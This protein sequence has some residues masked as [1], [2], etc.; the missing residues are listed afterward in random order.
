VVLSSPRSRRVTRTRTA[1]LVDAL[2]HT[3]ALIAG[4]VTY[5]IVARML[6]A[7]GLGLWAIIG[8]ASFLPLLCDMGL[9]TAVQRAAVGDDEARTRRMVAL[10]TL[11]VLLLAPVVSSGL[12]LYFQSLRAS[13]HALGQDVSRT[14]LLALASGVLAAL[15]MPYRSFAIARGGLRS[16]ALARTVGSAAQ[17]LVVLLG[18]V[19]RPS[20]VLPAAATLVG[21]V[22]ENG[23]TVRTA[24]RLDPELPLVP[25]LPRDRAEVLSAF[26]DGGAALVLNA[27]RVAAIRLDLMILS[28]YSPLSAIASYGVAARAGDQSYIVAKQGLA[29]LTP[30]LGDPRCREEALRLGAHLFA[31]VVA[32]GM[33]ALVLDGRC[34]LQVWAGPVAASTVTAHALLL[35]GTAAVIGSTDEVAATVLTLGGGTAWASATPRALGSAVNLAVSLAGAPRYGLWAVAGG[36]VIGNLVSS[37]LIWRRACRLLGW[38]T[39]DVVGV[40]TPALLALGSALAAG[41]MLGSF[42]QS[43]PWASVLSC[44][45]TTATGL[46]AA[47][48]GSRLRSRRAT[49]VEAERGKGIEACLSR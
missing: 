49:L 7:D 28:P 27:A 39:A 11:T 35:L 6:S 34:M 2:G 12:Y 23:M 3:G 14:A 41:V 37:L 13:S 48:L 18:V 40:F 45:L 17:I 4:L 22:L 46:C 25:W 20:L 42:A 16:I 21:L 19:L 10:A 33:A 47:L 38:S 44:G 9:S 43:G 24:R 26:R 15:A 36:T 29:A 1:L 30:R 31:T 5:P 32:C 8:S